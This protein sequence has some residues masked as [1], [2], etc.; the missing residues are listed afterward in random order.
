MV[1]EAIHW[2]VRLRFNQADEHTWRRFEHW[3]AQR[4][5][6]GLAWQRVQ[7]LGDEFAGIPVQLARH[8]LDSADRGMRR[9][10]SLKLL[11]LLAT[12]GATAWLGRDYTPLPAMLAQQHSGTGEQRS[13]QL[14]D[15]SLIQL[16]SNSAVDSA[17]DAQRRLIILRRGEIIVNLGADEHAAQHRPF[18]VQTRDGSIRVES[19][20]LLA[21]ERD[22]GTLL[23]LQ[24][25]AG[26]VFPGVTQAAADSAGRS[27]PTHGSLLFSADGAREPEDN[28]LDVWGW[29]AGVLS[30]RNMLL[31]DFLGELSRYRRGVIRCSDAIAGRRVSGTYQL[32]DPDQVLTLVAQSLRLKVDYRTRYWVTLTAAS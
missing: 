29:G 25:G 5:E 10:Q 11:G 9:R 18:W 6:H 12:V 28:G 4:P 17:F 13:F 31:R 16:N 3:L 1:D 27:V 26:T 24:G 19:A 14:D 7:T 23:A 21:R 32:T 22:D 2:L 30:A 20:R 8:T 15:G